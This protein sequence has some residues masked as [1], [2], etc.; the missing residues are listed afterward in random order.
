MG[1]EVRLSFEPRTLLSEHSFQSGEVL[2]TGVGDGGIGE[3]PDA[4]HRLQFWGIRG[5]AHNLNPVWMSLLGRDMK[6]TIVFDDQDVMLLA[7]PDT[8]R[9]SGH[10]HL[11]RLLIE[12][13]DDPEATFAGFWIDKGVH[14]EPF[15]AWVNGANERLSCRCPRCPKDGLEAQT[16]FIHGP[17]RHT[18][19]ETLRTAER[20]P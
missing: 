19:M 10:D 14:V 12:R 16:M 20:L 1:D 17:Q 18:R 11:I 7:R 9:E 13:R 4:F 3:V 8:G 5:E 2:R 15:I 6:T